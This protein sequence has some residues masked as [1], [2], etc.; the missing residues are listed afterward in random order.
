MSC[1]ISLS[2]DRKLEYIRYS[3][4]RLDFTEVSARL[5]A[6]IVTGETLLWWVSGF[7][8][9]RRKVNVTLQDGWTSRDAF[10]LRTSKQGLCILYGVHALHAQLRCLETCTSYSVSKRM[11]QSGGQTLI[12]APS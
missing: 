6:C 7:G 10:A 4:L 3:M 8:G 9:K 1:C 5:R 11:M 12:T 2:V